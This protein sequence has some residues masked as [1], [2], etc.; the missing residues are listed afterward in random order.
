M[1]AAIAAH[2]TLVYPQEA[3]DPALLLERLQLLRPPFRPATFVPHV[4]IVHPRTSRRGRELWESGAYRP[5]P[6]AFTSERS[7]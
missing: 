3:P 6:A 5:E 7:P 1:A 4:T 2:V